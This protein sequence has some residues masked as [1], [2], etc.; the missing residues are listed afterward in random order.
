MLA[1]LALAG[2]LLVAPQ[3]L[4]PEKPPL[5]AVRRLVLEHADVPGARVTRTKAAARDL[6]LDLAA[7]V[8]GGADFARIAAE[9]SAAPDARTGGELGALVPG[10][11]APELDAFLFAARDG[12]VSEP[13]DLASGWCILQRVPAHAA[14]LRIQVGGEGARRAERA[15]EVERRLRAGEDFALVARELSDD[16]ASAARGGQF[17][18]YERG[19]NDALLKRRAFESE[20][21]ATFGPVDLPPYGLNWIRRVPLD[22]VDAS[23]RE[24]RCVRLS[25][26]LF[27]FDTA[28]GADALRAPT[29]MAAKNAADAVHREL[30]AGADFARIA[31]ERT[32]DPGGRALGG[33][34]GWVH[35]NTPNLSEAVR[36]A[37]LLAPGFHTP[38]LRV[39]QGWVILKRDA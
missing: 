10:V 4:G 3:H 2:S 11:L 39:P 19:P 33:D 24:D 17:A 37:A 5:A 8:R 20:V 35:R 1:L 21:G 38:V 28:V 22:A 26:I 6:A 14:V 32:D 7:R 30:E 25:A 34:L 31:R 27:A 15:A 18:I 9:H 12:D 36:E 29:E 23:L 16:A 13:F